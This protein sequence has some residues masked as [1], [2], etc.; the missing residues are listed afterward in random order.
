MTFERAINT[1]TSD[2]ATES[3]TLFDIP[4]IFAEVVEDSF[5]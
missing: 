4:E 1:T 5:R 2:I 3:Q